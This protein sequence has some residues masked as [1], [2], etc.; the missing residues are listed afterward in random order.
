M[1]G[2]MREGREKIKD[3]RGFVLKIMAVSA[4]QFVFQTTYT[5]GLFLVYPGLFTLLL[6]SGII[7]SVLMA[8][9]LFPD[10]RE[11]LRNFRFL[12]GILLSVAGVV[13]TINAVLSLMNI[14]PN[15]V[16]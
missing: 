11:C 12:G 10:E 2:G 3:V 9:F 7:F 13:I 8:L 6:Q 1:S 16:S 15:C 5:L 4:V 14:F